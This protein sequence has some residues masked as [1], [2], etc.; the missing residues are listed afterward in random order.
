[1]ITAVAKTFSFDGHGCLRPITSFADTLNGCMAVLETRSGM[2]RGKDRSS[3]MVGN[4][5]T[6]NEMN[7]RQL[8]VDIS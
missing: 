6:M 1:M 2:H 3:T 5:A 4:E 8:A 7:Y